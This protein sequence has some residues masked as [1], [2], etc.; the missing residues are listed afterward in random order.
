MYKIVGADG[1]EYGPVSLEQMRQWIA[2]GR[3]GPQTRVQETSAGQWKTA[4]E[5]PELG[6]TAA[7]RTAGGGASPSP[8]AA[9][10]PAVQQKGLAITSLVLG[11][12]SVL[13]FGLFTGVPAI[14]C[15]HIAHNRTRRAPGQYGGSGPAIAG[16]VMGYVGVIL[17]LLLAALFLWTEQTELS[18]ALGSA[19]AKAQSINCMN[20]MKQIG[21]AFRTFAIDNDGNYPFN[22]STN[23]GGT[24]ELCLRGSDGFDRNAALHFQVMSNELAT[25]KILVCPADAKR[26]PALNFLSLR[27]EN[28]SYQVRS[29]TNINDN[30]PQEVLVV[31]PIH[32][33]V[34]LC[35]GSV[36]PRKRGRQ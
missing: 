30:N 3:V 36:Q 9:G 12:L 21:L 6:F 14:I 23:K 35:D 16:F 34:L 29:G 25:P 15:G 13:C 18:P 22:L 1:K 32:N 33:H 31:C 20:N 27:P 2:Q 26:Q 24:L 10:Q 7:A 17:S 19:K 5:F 11:L 28:V 8:A 4:A